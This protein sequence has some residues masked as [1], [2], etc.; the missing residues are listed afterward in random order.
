MEVSPPR[1][2]PNSVLVTTESV[3]TGAGMICDTWVVVA[4][5]GGASTWTGGR[6]ATDGFGAIW[7]DLAAG[8]L[9]EI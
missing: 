1:S 6:V 8:G 4:G 3:A 5:F 9:A 7:M 2:T